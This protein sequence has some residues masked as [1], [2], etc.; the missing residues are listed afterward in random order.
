VIETGGGAGMSALESVLG[1]CAAMIAAVPV[2][3]VRLD[4][5][6]RRWQ[7]KKTETDKTGEFIRLCLSLFAKL[8]FGSQAQLPCAAEI[9]GCILSV[10]PITL[11]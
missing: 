9:I 1:R 3:T 2:M 8:L 6:E 7:Q 4:A 10:A 5:A 11:V